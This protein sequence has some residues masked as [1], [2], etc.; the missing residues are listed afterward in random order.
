MGNYQ[1]QCTAC[2]QLYPDTG[3]NECPD[4]HTALQRT[5]YAT[6]RL[7]C[8]DLPGMM[9]F[10]DWLPIHYKPAVTA[11]PVTYRSVAFA[12]EM[13]FSNLY[14]T[15]NGFWPEKGAAVKTCSFKELEAVPT[16]QRASEKKS[17]I[18]VVASAGNTG[19]AFAQIAAEMDTPVVVVIPKKSLPRIWTTIQTDQVLLIT[20]DGDYS[21]AINRSITIANLPYLTA[22][23]GAKNCARR[24]GMGTV[25]LD[26]TTTIGRIPDYYV[27]AVGSGTGAI[28][29]WESAQRLIRD[30]RYG[31]HLPH[32][33][34]SQ[35]LPFVPM[36]NAWKAGRRE[37][38]ALTDMAD[39][40]T[41]I[42]QVYADVLT[43]RNPPY[44]ITG[45]LYDCLTET[46]GEIYSVSN[47]EARQAQRLFE[48]CEGIDLDPAAAVTVASLIT[49]TRDGNID[50]CRDIMV[51]ITGGGYKLVQEAFDLV[52]VNAALATDRTTGMDQIA[53]F[54]NDW[55]K[56]HA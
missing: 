25:M 41:T 47:N 36:A 14:I 45:G 33:I 7:Q 54:V 37:I 51:N 2:G 35:N 15:F 18:L 17:G 9:K 6:Q 26:A 4:R 56:E 38:D 29:A 46:G 31:S 16:L 43:N 8:A 13:G 34:L 12:R 23:G 42:S 3:S 52:P 53:G 55:V 21:D 44:S 1:I 39:A 49:A 24:D 30:G 27:Q 50:P 5:V 32:M 10:Y 28:A 20:V 40:P 22:E 19:R 48:E 11:G